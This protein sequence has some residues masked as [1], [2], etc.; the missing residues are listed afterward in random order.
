MS[1]DKGF[2]LLELAVTMAIVAIL[3]VAGMPPMRNL[4]LDARRA[5]VTNELVRALHVARS[6]SIRTSADVVVCPLDSG[7]GC[8]QAAD[9]WNG[10]WIV[11]VNGDRDEPPIRDADERLLLRFEPETQGTVSANRSS[12]V[13][14]PFGRRST[15]GTL[16]FCDARGPSAARAVIVSHTGRPRVSAVTPAG[17]PLT[18]P[19]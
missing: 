10:G 2:T 13:Y 14:R 12:F 5:R 17:S 15:T 7:A 18:C 8:S 19:G 4:L 11:F 1:G 9:G 6:E 16:V 3:L